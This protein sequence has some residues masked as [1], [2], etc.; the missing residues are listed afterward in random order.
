MEKCLNQRCES[1]DFITGEKNR[2]NC[3]VQFSIWECQVFEKFPEY[4][5]T[6]SKIKEIK[7]ME[8]NDNCD[9]DVCVKKVN[10]II[11]V[12]NRMHTRMEEK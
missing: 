6:D 12:F 11:D 9:L 1:N 2:N 4:F 10:E 7:K 3:S 5:Y 8:I